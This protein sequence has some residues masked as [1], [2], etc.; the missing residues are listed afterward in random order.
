MSLA[1]VSELHLHL[2]LLTSRNIDDVANRHRDVR[3]VALHRRIIQRQ[4]WIIVLGLRLTLIRASGLSTTR[5]EDGTP[6]MR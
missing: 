3:V 6:S 4:T 1:L 5:A 2:G